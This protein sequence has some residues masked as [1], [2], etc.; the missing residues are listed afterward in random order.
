MVQLQDRSQSQI[1]PG[2][3]PVT[4]EAARPK[5][6]PLRGTLELWPWL[7]GL[8]LVLLTVEWLVFLRPGRR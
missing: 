6:P 3:A 4:Q 5:G 1:L 2:T 8:G 7:A